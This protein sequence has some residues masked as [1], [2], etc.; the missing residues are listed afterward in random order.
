MYI[1]RDPNQSFGFDLKE[2]EARILIFLALIFSIK[3]Q[4]LIPRHAHPL[5]FS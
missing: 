5:I 1:S 3:Y 4:Y 2:L